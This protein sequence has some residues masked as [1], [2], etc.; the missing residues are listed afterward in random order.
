M[1][2][3]HIYRKRFIPS[4]IFILAICVVFYLFVRRSVST[5]LILFASMEVF[6]VLGALWAV[7]LIAKVNDA[8]DKKEVPLNKK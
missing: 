2:M 4:Q 6:N 7:R 1:T 8:Y 5:V 3:W